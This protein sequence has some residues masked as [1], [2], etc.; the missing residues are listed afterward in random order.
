MLTLESLRAWGADVDDGMKRCMNNEAFYFRMITK[1]MQ[2][3]RHRQS[4]PD[5]HRPAR[6]RDYRASPRPNTDGLLRFAE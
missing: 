4:G 6:T 3:T 5:P 2:E 1:A